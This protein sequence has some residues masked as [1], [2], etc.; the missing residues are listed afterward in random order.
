MRVSAKQVAAVNR[1]NRY[2]MRWKSFRETGEM[3]REISERREGREEGQGERRRYS[4]FHP[5]IF[6]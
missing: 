1:I 5:L 2:M 4:K 3:G 6:V